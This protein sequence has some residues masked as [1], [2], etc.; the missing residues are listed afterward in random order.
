MRS[1][2]E[3]LTAL[4]A[5]AEPGAVRVKREE[6]EPISDERFRLIVNSVTKIAISVVVAAIVVNCD[7]EKL[8][9]L[10]G[11]LLFLSLIHLE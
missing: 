4:T 5:G 10:A 3:T 1:I 7:R 9:I 8:G 6:H 11:T 2:K